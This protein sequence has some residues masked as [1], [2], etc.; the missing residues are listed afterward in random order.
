MTQKIIFFGLDG[1]T[2]TKLDKFMSQGIMPNLTSILQKGVRSVLQS[3]FPYTSR[4]S[5]VSMLTG[6]N[7]GKHGIPHHIVGGKQEIPSIW[8]KL[9]DAK[10]KCIVVHDLVTYPPLSVDGIMISGGFSTPSKSTNFVYPTN[11]MSEINDVSDGYIPSLD[12]Q[13]IKKV[14]EGHYDEFFDSLQEY[15]EK[16]TR[17]A[18]YLGNKFDWQVLAV[19]LENADYLHHYFWDKD[20]Y[21]ERFYSW[22]DKKLGEFYSF[23][24]SHNANL[25]V[26]SDHG[27]GPLKKHFLIN[28][29]LEQ[30]GLSHF[31][32]PGMVRKYL[33]NTRVKT[34]FSVK[35]LSRLH[36]RG[37]ASKVIP[38]KIKQVIPI[39]QNESAYID[40]S[41]KAYNSAYNE[42]TINEKDPNE[43]EKLREKIIKKLL[44]LRDDGTP[45]VLEAHKRE[46]VYH[47]PYVKRAHDI[48]CLLNNGYRS[49]TRF[50]EN[51]LLTSDE[52]G[53]NHSGDHRPEG[54]FFAVG[55]DIEENKVLESVHKIFDVFPTMLH[56]TNQPIPS[57]VD[58]KVMQEIFKKSS[59]LYN[60]KISI[61]KENEKDFIKN[62]ISK[63]KK[64]KSYG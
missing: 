55:P 25:L 63:M 59:P 2:W 23:A 38:A 16:I 4:T 20:S 40:Y 47:G 11:L 22:L 64:L 19:T 60:K 41:S 46:E 3:T 29:W 49:E 7:P 26:G 51:Y 21:L 15:A 34:D 14:N 39:E 10:I 43:Y 42:I 9:S 45:V 57:Y 28:T 53:I 30:T 27:F 8:E 61:S 44:E 32:R 54:I 58:G 52:L 18:L 56:M 6:T 36:L 35:S 5:W 12:F 31:G 62:R 1:G 24:S 37:L 17:T 48:I 50:R 13:I 33:A